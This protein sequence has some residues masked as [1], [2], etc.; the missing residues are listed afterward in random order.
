M[1][2]PKAPMSPYPGINA[3]YILSFVWYFVRIFL[4]QNFHAKD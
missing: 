4:L 3:G 1:A 2:E